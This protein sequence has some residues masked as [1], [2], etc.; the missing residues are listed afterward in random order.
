MVGLHAKSSELSQHSAVPKRNL[1]STAVKKELGFSD[2]SSNQEESSFWSQA[3][4]NYVR[5]QFAKQKA[6]SQAAALDL[7][8]IPRRRDRSRF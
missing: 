8:Q 7:A 5:P 6:T 3:E 1:A 2:S 4:A